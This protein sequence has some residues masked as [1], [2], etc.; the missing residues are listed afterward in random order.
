LGER[1]DHGDHA[2]RLQGFGKVTRDLTARVEAARERMFHELVENMPELAW[3]A[4][5]DG[6]V[7]FFNRR[8]FDY[9]GTTLEEMQGWG[10]RAVHDPAMVEAVAERWN[11]SLET[12]QPFEMEFPL[13]GADGAF[14]WFLTRVRPYRDSEGRVVRWFGTSTNIDERRRTDTFRDLFIGILGHDL[15]NPLNTIMMAARMM[16]MRGELSPENESMLAR[17]IASGVRIQRMIDQL[18]DMT[19]ARLAGGI[20]IARGGEQD[21][22]TIVMKIIDELRTVHPRRAIH[23]FADGP[24]AA[25]V[26][27]DRIEQVVSNLVTNALAHGEPS[28]PVTVRVTEDDHAVRIGVHNQGD[29][30]DPSFV[31]LLFNPFARKE[32]RGRSDGLGLGLYIAERIVFMHGGKIEVE[33][34]PETG[35]RFD[36]TLPKKVG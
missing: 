26:D 25:S 4:R 19:R 18:L 21:V 11:R 20:P 9:T 24:C 30:I 13:R 3:T 28:K 8:W 23:L 35:T 5:Q 33:S 1:D 32:Q 29:P 6:Y 36:V 31:P 15:R 2:G 10:W 12:G 7:D 16:S 22:V 14:Q 27:A 34:S 17:L